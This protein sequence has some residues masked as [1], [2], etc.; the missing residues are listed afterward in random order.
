MDIPALCGAGSIISNVLDYAKW[1]RMM[2]NRGDPL[3][4]AAHETIVTPHFIA[5]PPVWPHAS[6]NLYGFG[7]DVSTYHGE[8]VVWHLGGLPGWGSYVL[9]LPERSWGVVAFANT[10]DTSNS[11]EQELVF[12][13][14]DDLLGVPSAQRFDVRRERTG[15]GE[16]TSAGSRRTLQV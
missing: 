14:I 5:G 2:I 9:F 16:G 13:L 12:K 10:L 1:L 3:S 15:Q 7:W 6:A 8:K 11:A 4:A